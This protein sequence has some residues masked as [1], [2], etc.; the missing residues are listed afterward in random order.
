MG[1]R[2]YTDRISLNPPFGAPGPGRVDI[3]ATL[4]DP[5]GVIS[6]TSG[7]R[8]YQIAS[9]NVW[10]CSGGTVWALQTA[11]NEEYTTGV[12]AAWVSPPVVVSDALDRIAAYTQAMD[13]ALAAATV[14]GFPLGPIP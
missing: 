4:G 7:D 13:A 11:A 2:E 6:A 3:F 14:A 10:V 1:Q 12:P 8:A 9:N 5:N